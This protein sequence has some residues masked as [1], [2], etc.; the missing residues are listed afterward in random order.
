MKNYEL[1][2]ILPSSMTSKEI[3]EN[4]LEIKEN[5]IKLKGE[6]LETLLNHPFLLKSEISKDENVEELK[7]LP[8]TKRRLAYPIKKNKFG[9]YC[10]INFKSD[11]ENI[12]EMNNYLR[13]NRNII[14]HL[15][16][17]EDPMSKKELEKLQGL[18][19][20]KRAEQEKEKK[21][22]EEKDKKEK[23]EKIE[24]ERALQKKKVMEEKKVTAEKK[25]IQ[26]EIEKEKVE[27]IKEKIVE[28]KVKNK[29]TEKKEE[30]KEKTKKE[31][32]EKTINKKKKKIR[33][34]DLEDKL[35]EI[36]EDTMI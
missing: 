2:Y 35:D 24:K 6:M 23:T 14:R 13:M 8:V 30:K 33:L 32:K 20:R 17:Q 15:I 1:L 18:F 5:I 3:K 16:I 31:E 28:K 10:L 4:F 26:K 7:D 22:V 11:P 27:Q 19:A 29:I 36:L 25:E 9:F 34:E 12:N 21:E